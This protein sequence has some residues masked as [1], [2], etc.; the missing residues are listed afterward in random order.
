[1]SKEIEQNYDINKVGQLN[2]AAH[3]VNNSYY[4]GDTDTSRM[5][6]DF[7][8]LREEI[9]KGVTQDI[10]NELKFYIT[11]L[12][13][14]KS[15]EEKLAD[16]HF[17]EEQIFDAVCQKDMYARRAEL[18]QY[19]PSAQ[20][21]IFDLFSSIKN[22]FKSSIYPMIARGVAVEE[23]MQAVRNNIVLDIKRKLELMGSRDEYLHFSE[24]HIYGMIYY[25]TGMCHINWTVYKK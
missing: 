7:E 3:T 13:G 23:I 18:Y 20:Q 17:D 15:V 2:P 12:P 16:G 9:R 14:T 11:E 24:D 4:Y 6:A 10:I 1:M 19:Y 25:L 5:A 8:R 22:E 21:I